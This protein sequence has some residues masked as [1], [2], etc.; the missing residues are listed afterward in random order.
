MTGRHD[1]VDL[2]RL[3]A[4]AGLALSPAERD[5][6]ASELPALI[7]AADR[8]PPP[9]VAR[10]VVPPPP[11]GP[12]ACRLRDREPGNGRPAAWPPGAV[13]GDDGWLPVPRVR[14]EETA[15]DG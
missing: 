5:R 12:A 14:E 13:P 3:A 6:L 2:D 7:A 4:L 11:A 8:L 15:G 9:P 1:I 10:H